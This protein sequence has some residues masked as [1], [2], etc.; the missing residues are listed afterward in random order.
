MF[1]AA[2]FGLL[3]LV[4][5]LSDSPS[6]PELATIIINLLVFPILFMGI[7]VQI[8]RWH[9]RDKSGWW[10]FINFVPIVGVLWALIECAYVKG[11][12]GQNRFGPD[13]LQR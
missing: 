8:K 9:D 4:G 13:P 6:I 3:L 7:I 1:N 10:I 5:F 12:E 11:T 2:L